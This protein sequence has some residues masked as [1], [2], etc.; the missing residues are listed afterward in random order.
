MRQKH[1]TEFPEALFALSADPWT[2]GHSSVLEKAK[3]KYKGRVLVG[4][5]NDSKK[6]YLFPQWARLRLAQKSLPDMDPGDIRLVPGSLA[7]YLMREDVP[8]LIRGVRDQLDAAAEDTLAFY[9]L[10]ENPDLKIDIMYADRGSKYAKIS[11]TGVKASLQAGNR[12]SRMVTSTV[13][14]ALESRLIGQYPVCVTGEMGAGKSTISRELVVEAEK[15]GI[16]CIYVDFD[17]L[18]HDIYGTL[19]NPYYAK[20]RREIRD[21]FGDGVMGTDGFVDRAAL[22]QAVWGNKKKLAKLNRIMEEPLMF[23]Y[24]DVI[25]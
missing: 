24:G 25:L 5:A 17:S 22:A 19:T 18:A 4:I 11:S 3:N 16:P 13:K 7:R 2:L 15:L 14:Q 23:R 6:D 21:A 9:Y 12:I 1:R 20:V 8:T 10:E